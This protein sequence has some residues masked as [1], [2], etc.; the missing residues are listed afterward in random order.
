MRLFVAVWPSPEAHAALAALP[1]PVTPAVRWTTPDQ[2]HVTLR[3]LGEVP[4]P[5][6]VAEALHR[7]ASAAT[8]SSTGAAD[9]GPAV[10]GP[11]DAA[12]ADAGSADAGPAE[13]GPATAW[14]PGRRVLQ[15]PVAGLDALAAAVDDVLDPSAR[16][17]SPAFSGHVTVARARGRGR[18]PA[19]LAG[20]PCSASWPV[21]EVTLVRSFPGGGGSRYE[22]LARVASGYP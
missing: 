3:F 22:V 9:P 16:P 7:L 13:M 14:F 15:V 10:A 4:D 8:P 2:W 12:A 1:R 19:S 20:S 11:T 21:P 5:D 18:G 6:P 17:R